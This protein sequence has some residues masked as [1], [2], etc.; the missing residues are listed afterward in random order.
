MNIYIYKSE[1]FYYFDWHR[2]PACLDF[3]EPNFVWANVWGE[4]TGVAIGLVKNAE[5]ELFDVGAVV[6][7]G[8]DNVGV[9]VGSFDDHDDIFALVPKPDDDEPLEEF[10]FVLFGDVGDKL[11]RLF[12]EFERRD[13]VSK[14][15]GIGRNICASGLNGRMDTSESK[16]TIN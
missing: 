10:K 7:V 4:K 11:I 13:I 12:I 16:L 1:E 15:S 9:T 3:N 2:F 8:D 14:L 5:F 6:V